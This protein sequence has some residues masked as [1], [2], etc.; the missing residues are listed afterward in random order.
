MII[1]KAKIKDFDQILKLQLELEDAECKFDSNLIER[2]YS[3]KEGKKR[4]KERIKNKNQV[5]L[6]AESNNNILGFIDGRM[7]DEA[8]W[9]K[10]KVGILEHI[11]VR[12]ENRRENVASN[13]LKEF[14]HEIINKGAIYIQILAFP[15]NIP[16][17]SLY[18]KHGYKEYSVYLSKRINK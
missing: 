13:L 14:E 4:L 7:M 3:T 10:E 2:C 6:V 5:F 17:I 16:A 12:K 1:R 9:Y 18:N 11:C 15:K 8:I